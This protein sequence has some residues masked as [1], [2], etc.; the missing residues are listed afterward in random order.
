MV[1]LVPMSECAGAEGILGGPERAKGIETLSLERKEEHPKVDSIQ[2]M[3][4]LECRFRSLT[5]C[6][7]FLSFS[8]RDCSPRSLLL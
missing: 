4:G 7:A 5:A 3:S 1:G 6:F 8:S 2:C